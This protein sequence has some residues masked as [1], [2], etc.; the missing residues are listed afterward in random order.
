MS[1]ELRSS[2]DRQV[3]VDFWDSGSEDAASAGWASAA[4][5]DSDNHSAHRTAPSTNRACVVQLRR[6]IAAFLF[7]RR[8]SGQSQHSSRGALMKKG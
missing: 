4:P 8:L 3:D 2:D 6:L 5:G 1:L 7:I